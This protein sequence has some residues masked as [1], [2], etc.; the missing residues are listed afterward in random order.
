[1]ITQHH[2]TNVEI[3]QMG[4]HFLYLPLYYARH[5]DFFGYIP[6]EYNID[7][8]HAWPPTDQRAYEMLMDTSHAECS[9]IAFAICDPTRILD[10]ALNVTADP[11]ILA[12]LITNAAFWAIDRRS[13]KLVY[14]KD[15]ADFSEIICYGQGTT[16]YGIARRIFVRAQKTPSLF[17]VEP[18][19]EFTAL[20]NRA[21][22]IAISPDILSA[23]ELVYNERD[24]NIDM[25][26]GTT[27]ECNN[28]L[29]TGIL[30]RRD[31]VERHKMFVNGLLKGIQ[32][33]ALA[34]Q[35][36]TPEAVSF[37]AGYF[38]TKPERVESAL[39]RANDALVFAGRIDVSEA[40]WMRAAE[41]F[42]DA[43]AVP[44]SDDM[45]RRAR[46][47]Y[48]SAVKPYSSY[49]RSAI[50]EVMGQ[51]L[52]DRRPTSAED[53]RRFVRRLV[54]VAAY[55]LVGALVTKYISLWIAA[56]LVIFSVLWLFVGRFMKLTRS[57]RLYFYA[58]WGLFVSCVAAYL[59]NYFA[60]VSAE[61]T[62][63]L[64]VGFLLADLGIFI[65][66]YSPR[67]R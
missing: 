1:M 10:T 52:L 32:K 27:V 7:I 11:V 26:L 14:L 4:R 16:S 65:A 61:F 48:A 63:S 66:I 37:A 22:A 12:A 8:V 46:E 49:A 13:K 54:P 42:C 28:V 44:F 35:F 67:Q 29:V 18:A 43:H 17:P 5:N 53:L 41:S 57:H 31:F 56:M 38:N 15:I 30:S 25:A 19:Q 45:Q 51:T 58:H 64:I 36:S 6:S 9:R 55:G 40:H 39:Q 21:G 2:V 20:K 23:D 59:C 33:A 62:A 3:V 24:F 34:V 60:F 50:K 47:A